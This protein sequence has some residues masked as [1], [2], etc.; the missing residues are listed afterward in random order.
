MLTIVCDFL[1]IK[2]D[3]FASQPAPSPAVSTT[4][5]V[6]LF[7]S[8]PAVSTTMD[9]FAAPETASQIDNKAAKLDATSNFVDPF[10]NVPLNNFDGTDPFDAFSSNTE[11]LSTVSN[12]SSNTGRNGNMKGASTETKPLPKDSF[13]VKSGIWADS[14]SRGLIDLNISARKYF[15]EHQALV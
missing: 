13:Q 15:S 4:V 5:G 8:Q 7:A 6:D 3:L 1:L 10:A 14:L 9:F 2:V 12:Q 11:P